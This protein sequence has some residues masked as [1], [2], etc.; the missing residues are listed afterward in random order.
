MARSVIVAGKFPANDGKLAKFARNVEEKLTGNTRYPAPPVPPP[1]LG[2]LLDAFEPTIGKRGPGTASAR[3]EARAKVETA[4]RQDLSYVESGAAG[5]SPEDA[6]SAIEGAGYSVKKK[7]KYS[8]PAYGIGRGQVEGSVLAKVKAQ[9]RHGSVQYCHAHSLDGG[10][11][12]IDHPPTTEASLAISGLPAATWVS[13]RF[14]TLK[15]GA[16]GDWSQVLKI[17]IS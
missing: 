7:G 3:R 11:T 9:G 16:Y 8:K 14:R 5:L 10:T 2:A 15:K 4:L 1:A 12:W 13:F 6:A 17:L